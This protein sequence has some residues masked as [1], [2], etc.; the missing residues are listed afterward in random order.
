M[1]SAQQSL[2]R[3]PA[4]D[5]ESFA[6]ALRTAIDASELGLSQLQLRLRQRG[7]RV[8]VATLSYWQTG[9][10]RPER[11][12]SFLAVEH[13][14]QVLGLQPHSLRSLLGP[15]RPRGRWA[16]REQSPLPMSALWPERDAVEAA[17]QVLD[18]RWDDALERISLHDRLTVGPDRREQSYRMRQVLRAKCNGPDRAVH[19]YRLDEP[20]LPLPEL[21]SLRGCRPGRVAAHPGTGLL[22]AE[23]LFDQPLT[24]GET[25]IIEF[26]LRYGG[27]RP[28]ATNWE[29]KLRMPIRQYDLEIE[30]TAP[31][32]P[33]AFEHFVAPGAD[34]SERSRPPVT[35]DAAHRVHAVA[36]DLTPCRYGMRWSWL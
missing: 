4:N 34:G 25:V 2:T 16:A 33:V 6:Q 29:R 11:P 31:A 26:E 36:L 28:L 10:S 9:R 27:Q 19:V 12:D 15:R 13:I 17:V 7:V 20:H 35:L 23:L 1:P 14:E 24:Q 18:L 32:L 22:A 5:Q 8:S 30:F 21:H 3:L